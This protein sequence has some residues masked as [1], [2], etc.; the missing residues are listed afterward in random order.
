MRTK[1]IFAFLIVTFI[2]SCKKENEFIMVPN[3]NGFEIYMTVKPHTN[4]LK[5]DYSKV[6]FDTIVLYDKPIIR[7][8]DLISYDTIKHILKLGISHDSLDFHV[9]VTGRMFVLTIDKIP[10][11]CGFLWPVTSSIP[12]NWVYI[13]EP[14]ESLDHLNDNEIVIS[15]MSTINKEPAKDPRLDKRIIDRLTKDKKIK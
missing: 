1:F 9:A 14:H 10:I 11:Y 4:N 5:V 2:L 12:C 7:Y 8:Q 6:D 13:L 3:N 15:F